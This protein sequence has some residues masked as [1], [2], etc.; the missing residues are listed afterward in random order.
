MKKFLLPLALLLS[1]PVFPAGCDWARYNMYLFAPRQKKTIPA[2]YSGLSE[3]KLAVLVFMK[4]EIRDQYPNAQS[5]ITRMITGE[6][7][8]AS[9][10]SDR[11]KNR[12]LDDLDLVDYEKILRFQRAYPYWNSMTKREMAQHLGADYVLI[13]SVM[14]FSTREYSD[15]DL[16][17]GKMHASARLYDAS[18][19]DAESCVWPV[20]GKHNASFSHTYPQ[21]TAAGLQGREDT[22][23]RFIVMKKLAQALTSRFYTHKIEVKPQDEPE[24]M[25]S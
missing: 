15:I 17:R 6:F 7:M 3:K 11:G 1:V 20:P 13:V 9:Q 16:F 21:D 10:D 4:D 12:E 2:E 8:L 14:G 18:L 5:Q 25:H 23:V 22:E 19:P 24:P